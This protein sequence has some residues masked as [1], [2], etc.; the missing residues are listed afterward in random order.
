MAVWQA[1]IFSTRG[2]TRSCIGRSAPW[3]ER[4]TL[5]R[6]FWWWWRSAS[7]GRAGSFNVEIKKCA[8]SCPG[9]ESGRIRDARGSPAV[10]PL[11]GSR[12]DSRM[13]RG[14]WCLQIVER[15]AIAARRSGASARAVA[16][17][18]RGRCQTW[19]T[20]RERD[21]PC[22]GLW[23]AQTP[24]GFRCDVMLRI[25]PEFSGPH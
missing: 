5:S 25:A 9:G 13:P 1:E 10:S 16:D 8:P 18:E 17:G 7:R 11:C 15:V 12:V 21:V 2:A 19:P 4:P 20:F 6:L 3:S 22:A 14:R 24:E 23:L